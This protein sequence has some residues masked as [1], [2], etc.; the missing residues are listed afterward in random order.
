MTKCAFSP[1]CSCLHRVSACAARA[2]LIGADLRLDGACLM[3]H[4]PP[5]RLHWLAIMDHDPAAASL[6][7]LSRTT[8]LCFFAAK[9]VNDKLLPR[10]HE[11]S[12]S[13]RLCLLSRVEL[14]DDDN[15]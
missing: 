8:V 15:D 1:P 3:D 7:L 4:P 12:F 13:V 9:T 10:T 11:I 2:K 14:H 6:W 5:L